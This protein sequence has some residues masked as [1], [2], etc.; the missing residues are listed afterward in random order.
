MALIGTD[1]KKRKPTKRCP[2]ILVLQLTQVSLILS[3]RRCNA[4]ATGEFMKRVL[5]SV[6]SL[7]VLSVPSVP[8]V[9]NSLHGG[10]GTPTRKIRARFNSAAV[11][12]PCGVRGD[13]FQEGAQSIDDQR[14][15]GAV[16]IV[17]IGVRQE[18][19]SLGGLAR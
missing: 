14:Q 3:A 17:V 9:V 11:D 5:N 1:V 6:L 8:S 18:D 19:L 4:E 7:L 13:L 12:L 15:V 2:A 16:D 10:H